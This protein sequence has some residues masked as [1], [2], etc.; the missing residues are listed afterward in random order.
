MVLQPTL[1]YEIYV[2]AIRLPY[3]PTNLKFQFDEREKNEHAITRVPAM[4]YGIPPAVE[5]L[6]FDI[7]IPRTNDPKYLQVSLSRPSDP[8]TPS[9]EMVDI[10]GT[11]TA[12]MRSRL[13][14]E[15]EIRRYFNPILLNTMRDGPIPTTVSRAMPFTSG[16]RNISTHVDK[17]IITGLDVEEIST[18]W[19]DAVIHVQ[20]QK[21][22]QAQRLVGRCSFDPSHQNM[23]MV[24]SPKGE[25]DDLR[26]KLRVRAYTNTSG[27][28][29]IYSYVS[30]LWRNGP[31]NETTVQKLH[32]YAGS[33][34]ALTAGTMSVVQKGLGFVTP[35]VSTIS[36]LMGTNSGWAALATAGLG[37]IPAVGPVVAAIPALYAGAT[38]AFRGLGSL[39]S[40]VASWLSPSPFRLPPGNEADSQGAS[41][42][43]PN[44]DPLVDCTKLYWGLGFDP[45]THMEYITNVPICELPLRFGVD[46]PEINFTRDDIL[47]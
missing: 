6:A 9:L 34:G 29:S 28:S 43:V 16:T 46:V 42:S 38:A 4:R 3:N 1:Y 41:Q 15:V 11:L 20:M 19:F 37:A 21:F 7:Q 2:D 24:F 40:G 12:K 35:F 33:L 44:A 17:Y 36:G 45:K 14:V 30:Q 31:A 23:T 18:S 39:V 27:L 32:R 47:G 10:R 13:P 25:Y 5:T 26:G 22:Y 8:S